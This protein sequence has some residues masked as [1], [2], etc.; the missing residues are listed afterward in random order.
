[1]KSPKEVE[2]FDLCRCWGVDAYMCGEVDAYMSKTPDGDFV[3]IEDYEELWAQ[4]EEHLK[5][6]EDKFKGAANAESA[7]LQ[8]RKFE[9]TNQ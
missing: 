4:V 3:R 9:R 7:H 5:K 8:Y 6:L 2:R 1:M